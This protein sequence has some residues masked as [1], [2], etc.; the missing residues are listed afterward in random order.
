M[1]DRTCAYTRY[2]HRSYSA[3]FMTTTMDLSS[4]SSFSTTT[5][6]TTTSSHSSL[7]QK[8]WCK[9]NSNRPRGHPYLLSPRPSSTPEELAPLVIPS[10]P[11]T[12]YPL[13]I[14][15]CCYCAPPTRAASAISHTY[16]DA[17]CN[18]LV[19]RMRAHCRRRVL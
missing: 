2:Q 16:S 17:V 7:S 18:A 14:E 12:T 15:G 8:G 4:S 6:S 3:G 10:T 5:S 1:G 13:T 19:R 11:P 9:Q